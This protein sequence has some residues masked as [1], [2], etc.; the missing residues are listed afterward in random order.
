MGLLVHGVVKIEFDRRGGGLHQLNQYL[1]TWFRVQ[2]SKIANKRLSPSFLSNTR[3]GDKRW[4]EEK[5]SIDC[6]I[7]LNEDEWTFEKGVKTRDQRKIL[8][9]K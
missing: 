8:S 5:N 3:Q 9:Y 1:S 6:Q 7:K 2:N 4:N